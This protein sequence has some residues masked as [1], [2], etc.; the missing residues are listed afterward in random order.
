[1]RLFSLSHTHLPNPPRPLNTSQDTQ[2]WSATAHCPELKTF[3]WSA[4]DYLYFLTFKMTP[5]SSLLW[6]FQENVFAFDHPLMIK[7]GV[8]SLLS[9][10]NPTQTYNKIVYLGMSHHIWW[11]GLMCPNAF[12][13]FDM[14]QIWQNITN[15]SVY[16]ISYHTSSFTISLTKMASILDRCAQG[17]VSKVTI[18]DGKTGTTLSGFGWI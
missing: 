9:F 6:A 16:N 1:M 14:K 3:R 17:Y 13:T 4:V 15:I 12:V 18:Q 5:L 10:Y 8:I 7:S 11:E 2:N